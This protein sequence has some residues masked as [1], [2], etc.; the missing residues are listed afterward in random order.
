MNLYES[1]DCYEYIGN[2]KDIILKN[3][4]NDSYI[5]KSNNNSFALFKTIEEIIYI[6]YSNITSMIIFNLNENTIVTE[7]KNAM[8]DCDIRDIIH[9]LDE[10][11]KRDLILSLSEHSMALWNI[12]KLELLFKKVKVNRASFLKHNNEIYIFTS[13][14][15]IGTDDEPYKVYDLKGNLIKKIKHN[16]FPTE[17]LYIYQNYIITAH[18]KGYIN[19]YN[20]LK[21]CLYYK[22]DCSC[23]DIAVDGREEDCI[24]LFIAFSTIKIY[25]FHKKILLKEINIGVNVLYLFNNE[26]LFG[27]RG[28]I[29]ILVNLKTE[30]EKILKSHKNRILSI[31]KI[32]HK[33]Y[34]PCLISQGE[35]ID[36]IKC[37]KII[38]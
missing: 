37:W 24:K 21:E 36:N 9:C 38:F 26:Y 30:K 27:A 6:V 7:I 25:D 28:G 18:Y 2:P 12:S 15:L 22:L 13:Y 33:N 1:E 20:Y 23:C 17:F 31:K 3:K 34:G 11:N 16:D 10:S 29:I 5:E 4:L 32:I 35:L 8:G 14:G 19:I